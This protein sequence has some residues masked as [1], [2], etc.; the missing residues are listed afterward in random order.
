MNLS[1]AQKWFAIIASSIV[2][3]TSGL[4]LV[5]GFFGIN[6]LKDTVKQLERKVSDLTI[7]VMQ[8][9]TR[10]E[11]IGLGDNKDYEIKLLNDTN[12]LVYS[13]D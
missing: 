3:M 10:V 2:I 9:K 8:V 11:L 12:R 6:D 1:K 13:S 7:V 5:N 4:T